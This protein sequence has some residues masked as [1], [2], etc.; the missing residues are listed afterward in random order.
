[1][2]KYLQVIIINE[3]LRHGCMVCTAKTRTVTILIALRCTCIHVWMTHTLLTFLS[4]FS[5]PVRSELSTNCS[6]KYHVSRRPI[7]FTTYSHHTVTQPSIATPPHDNI[8]NHPQGWGPRAVLELEDPKS[9]PWPWPL[10]GLALA[11]ASIHRPP[12]TGL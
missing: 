1:M 6:P 5:Q 3:S 2:Y 8:Y 7:V 4:S 12:V 9:W 11:L 10:S